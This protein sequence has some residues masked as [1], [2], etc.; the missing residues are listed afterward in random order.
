MSKTSQDNDQESKIDMK[1]WF[2]RVDIR[3]VQGIP[4]GVASLLFITWPIII[5]LI[6][7]D[8]LPAN[9]DWAH[10]PYVNFIL[11]IIGIV[12]ILRK[13]FYWSP[14]TTLKGKW[15]ILVGSI[16]VLVC[17]VLGIILLLFS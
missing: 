9:L 2:Y 6:Y 16:L 8:N 13:E 1:E 4:L 10:L 14:R 17:I 5:K 15:A 3:V 11:S 12:G 7:D